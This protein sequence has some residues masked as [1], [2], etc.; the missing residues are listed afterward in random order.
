LARLRPLWSDPVKRLRY[1]LRWGHV[2][3]EERIE[4]ARLGTGVHLKILAEVWGAPY[5]E[6]VRQAD[7]IVEAAPP[8]GPAR[9]AA[10]R[11]ARAL[12]P[13]C[14]LWREQNQ[15]AQSAAG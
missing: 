15:G 14:R 2:H 6:K 4:A 5:P 13:F 9:G 12:D 1:D 11:Q 7:A 3:A 10:L 8:S